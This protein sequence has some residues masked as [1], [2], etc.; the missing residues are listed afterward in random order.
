MNKNSKYY[1]KNSNYI[2]TGLS[3]LEALLGILILTTITISSSQLLLPSIYSWHDKTIINAISNFLTKIKNQ[4][5][6][7]DSL[8]EIQI[9][10]NNTFEAFIANHKSHYKI[11]DRLNLN[12]YLFKDYKINYK[13]F[14]SKKN[15][16]FSG[17]NYKDYS[18][19]NLIIHNNYSNKEYTITIK[20]GRIVNKG[21]T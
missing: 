21:F 9:K 11:I 18:N 2:Q 17:V 19:G 3:L 4:A 14:Y 8:I 1:L 6:I 7:T 16:I 20:A 13:S 5:V 12:N 15:I 10:K